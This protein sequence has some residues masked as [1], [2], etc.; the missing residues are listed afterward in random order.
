M[1]WIGMK[2]AGLTILSFRAL[3]GLTPITLHSVP[4]YSRVNWTVAIVLTQT[5]EPE[6]TVELKA[7]AF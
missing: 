1:Y 3:T 7:Q 6:W 4:H 5:D 2:R